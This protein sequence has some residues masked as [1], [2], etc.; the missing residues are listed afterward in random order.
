MMN[1]S[2]I[3]AYNAL[4]APDRRYPID[5]GTAPAFSIT[6]NGETRP[7][8]G[9]ASGRKEE[10]RRLRQQIGTMAAEAVGELR[11]SQATL[12]L[13]Q[14]ALATEILDYKRQVDTLAAGRAVDL[15][16]LRKHGEQLEALAERFTALE[17]R[18][19]RIDDGI[20]GTIG[21][22]LWAKHVELDTF[23][24]AG[25]AAVVTGTFYERLRWLFLGLVPRT[26]PRVQVLGS[27]LAPGARRVTTRNGDVLADEAI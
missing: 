4:T 13:Q 9:E 20:P 21:A 24:H 26:R 5:W 23:V 19:G 12:Q 25:A 11:S 14:R 10:N 15:R 7:P 18:V 6:R 3:A 1:P 16:E 22:R 2:V 27:E 17:V 8:V